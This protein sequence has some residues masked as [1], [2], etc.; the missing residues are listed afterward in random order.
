V[1]LTTDGPIVRLSA[2]RCLVMTER[3]G[4]PP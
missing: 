1:T 3:Q 2:L 4:C